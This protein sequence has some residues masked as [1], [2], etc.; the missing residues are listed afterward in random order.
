MHIC[1]HSNFNAIDFET[2]VSTFCPDILSGLLN[3]WKHD[4]IIST[5][6]TCQYKCAKCAKIYFPQRCRVGTW[7]WTWSWYWPWSSS[8][9]STSWGWASRPISPAVQCLLRLRRPVFQTTAQTNFERRRLLT[10]CWEIYFSL[11]LPCLSAAKLRSKTQS[12]SYSAPHRIL[13]FYVFNVKPRVIHILLPI[14]YWISMCLM[15]NQYS[16][17]PIVVA[18]TNIAVSPNCLNYLNLYEGRNRNRI[19][20]ASTF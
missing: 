12:N 5:C 20:F 16:L 9:P 19:Y 1:K 10:A 2:M 4:C 3:A 14:E 15:G 17:F 11:L 13:N 7:S 8:W 18:T 6:S